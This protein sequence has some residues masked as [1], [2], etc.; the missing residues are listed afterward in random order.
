MNERKISLSLSIPT[1]LGYFALLNIFLMLVLIFTDASP[2]IAR[3]VTGVVN[4]HY[5]GTLFFQRLPLKIMID[6]TLNIFII[7]SLYFLI[8]KKERRYNINELTISYKEEKHGRGLMIK[9]LRVRD[10]LG[11]SI[12]ELI[13]NYSGWSE[14]K[15][16]LIF[17][18]LD[19]SNK[20]NPH[21][22]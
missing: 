16:N 6:K 19:S 12:F 20:C 11:I 13:P 3:I 22:N 7:E 8:Q 5:I 21:C 14:D 9:T 17:E 15:L 4:A 2:V 10:R 1:I 18:T